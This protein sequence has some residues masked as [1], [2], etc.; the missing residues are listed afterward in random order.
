LA[1][2]VSA[3]PAALPKLEK[4][5]L[6]KGWIWEELGLWGTAGGGFLV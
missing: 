3:A 5:E 4:L 2:E 1:A 6:A